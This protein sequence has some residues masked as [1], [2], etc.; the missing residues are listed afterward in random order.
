VRPRGSRASAG[1]GPGASAR[2]WDAFFPRWYRCVHLVEP[3]LRRWLRTHRIGDT[4]ELVVPGRRT[5]LPRSV[6][7]GLLELRGRR[8][9]GHPTATCAWTSNLEAAGTCTI[10][11]PAGDPEC[12]RA[13]RLEPG[14]ERDAVIRATFRQHPFPG[15]VIYWLARGHVRATGRF[16]RLEPAE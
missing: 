1:T 4:V 3:L 10:T 16:Y 5:G 12:F 7:V 9:V 6:L 13:V 14:P 8:Y 15:D 2:F 11:R